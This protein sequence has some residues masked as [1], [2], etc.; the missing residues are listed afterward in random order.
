M[1]PNTE[2]EV[3]GGLLDVLSEARKYDEVVKYSKRGLR[4]AEATN[5][6]LFYVG[7]GLVVWGWDAYVSYGYPGGTDI[8]QINPQ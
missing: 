2:A 4:T 1:T 7:V 8:R 5:R 6:V 3:Y